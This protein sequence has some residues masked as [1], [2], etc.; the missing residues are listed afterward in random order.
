MRHRDGAVVSSTPYAQ[1]S[2]APDTMMGA[3]DLC[4]GRAICD[5]QRPLINVERPAENGR[6]EI[7]NVGFNLN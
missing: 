3:G 7:V 5:L 2:G 1:Q 4:V 6:T